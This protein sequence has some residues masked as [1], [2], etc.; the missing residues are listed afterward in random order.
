MYETTG[1]YSSVELLQ[2]RSPNGDPFAVDEDVSLVSDSTPLCLKSELPSLEDDEELG[3]CISTIR[4]RWL[5]VDRVSI[6]CQMR[7]TTTE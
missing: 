5:R 6:A 7:V 2:L 4:L 1:K 3:A